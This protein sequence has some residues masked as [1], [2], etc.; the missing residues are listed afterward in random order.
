MM[1]QQSICQMIDGVS[2]DQFSLSCFDSDIL[3]GSLWHNANQNPVAGFL[4]YW[5]LL[6]LYSFSMIFRAVHISRESLSGQM[7]I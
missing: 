4:H 6:S 1:E 3:G 7:C 2:E 5:V